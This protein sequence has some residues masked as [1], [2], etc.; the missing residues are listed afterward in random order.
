MSRKAEKVVV[1][2]RGGEISHLIPD[3]INP[4]IYYVAKRMPNPMIGVWAM[5]KSK[6]AAADAKADK[7]AGIKEGSKRDR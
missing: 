1:P 7:K 2:L 3:L 6:K 5:M 4:S